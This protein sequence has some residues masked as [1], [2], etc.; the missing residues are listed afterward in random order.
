MGFTIWAVAICG[1]LI[2]DRQLYRF[3]TDRSNEGKVCKVGLWRYSRHPN[4]FFEWIHWWA[5]VAIGWGAPY[6][7]LTLIG[8]ALMLFFLFKVTGIPPNEENSLA[9]R[10]D[11]YREYQRTTSIFYPWPPKQD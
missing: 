6:G 2:V 3:R 7:A 5:Y 11:A 9:S 4:Y 8:P 10:R 1:E